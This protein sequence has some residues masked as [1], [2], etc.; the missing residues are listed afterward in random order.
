M[1]YFIKSPSLLLSLSSLRQGYTTD[2][3]LLFSMEH[4]WDNSGTTVGHQWN[5]PK[6]T[7]AHGR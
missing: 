2:I 7:Q 3:P 6:Q 1:V 4:Q 5:I